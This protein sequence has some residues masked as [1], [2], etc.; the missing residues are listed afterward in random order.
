M[1]EEWPSFRDDLDAIYPRLTALSAT[2]P[3][4]LLE[5]A[6]AAHNPLGD[7]AEWAKS[8]LSD[9]TSLRWRR[10]IGFS[11]WNE[12]WQNDDNPQHDTTMRVQ[13]NPQLAQV[14][15]QLVGENPKVLG[16][17]VLVTR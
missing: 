10:I 16:R 5:F 13:D 11:W 14:F 12:A 1:A 8:A 4:A 6:A 2:K 15:Q 7:Q 3:I 17:A 9:L